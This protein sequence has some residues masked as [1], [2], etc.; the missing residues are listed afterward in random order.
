M[1]QFD[2]KYF[3]S[4][5]LRLEVEAQTGNFTAANGKLYTVS[6]AGAT[7]NVQL[8][9]PAANFHCIIKDLSGDMDTKT[10]TIVRNGVEL[11]DGIAAN[12]TLTS[13][14][15]SISLFSDGTNWFRI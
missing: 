5:A 13:E 11:I 9:A 2:L 8:P 1:S 15:E 12:I 7:L 6:P 10:T 14:Y 3:P 4:Q